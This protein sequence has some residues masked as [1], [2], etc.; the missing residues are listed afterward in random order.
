MLDLPT[1]RELLNYAVQG[2]NGNR[3]ALDDYDRV[4]RRVI[5]IMHRAVNRGVENWTD[6]RQWF[7]LNTLLQVLH[8]LENPDIQSSLLQ[9]PLYREAL[10]HARHDLSTLH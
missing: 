4:M 1:R 6:Y 8:S 9:S 2:L 7:Q 5:H 3:T 10:D